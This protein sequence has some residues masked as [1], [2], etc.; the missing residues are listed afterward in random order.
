[1]A[2]NIS[3]WHVLTAVLAITTLIFGGLTIA[4]L[5]D[6]EIDNENYFDADHASDKFVATTELPTIGTDGKLTYD[7]ISYV[8]YIEENKTEVKADPFMSEINENIA[9]RSA[10]IALL[11]AEWTDE[12]EWTD[13]DGLI[14][15]VGAKYDY[16]DLINEEDVKV[17]IEDSPSKDNAWD[18]IDEISATEV[19]AE[20]NE[21]EISY[22]IEIEV[23]GVDY[24][25]DVANVFEDGKA[26]DLV[27]TQ[28]LP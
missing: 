18:L 6:V 8:K 25:Y 13:V 3:I 14:G 24:I 5:D 12:F 21:Y 27:L 9:I 15:A 16:D 23:D 7:N 11:N 17:V 2:T 26:E 19:D 20:D 4:N 28:E 22:T 10:S 1:M